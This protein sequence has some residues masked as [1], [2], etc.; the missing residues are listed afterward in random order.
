LAAAYRR[1]GDREKAH[2]SLSVLSELLREK[3]AST[4]PPIH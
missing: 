1:L 2:E 4:S 3:S